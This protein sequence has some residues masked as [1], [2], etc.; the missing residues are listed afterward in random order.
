MTRNGFGDFE[1]IVDIWLLKYVM[2]LLGS[3]LSV[4]KTLACELSMWFFP[5]AVTLVITPSM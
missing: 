2:K 5:C 3:E 4:L 1:N